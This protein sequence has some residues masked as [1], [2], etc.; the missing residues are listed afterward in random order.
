V[1]AALFVLC[2]LALLAFAS[3]AR[4]DDAVLRSWWTTTPLSGEY[5]FRAGD[6]PSWASPDFDDSWWETMNVPEEFGWLRG[7]PRGEYAWLRRRV[8]LPSDAPASTGTGLS[9]GLVNGA[10]DVFV[11]GVR[12]GSCGSVE[13]LEYAH[14]SHSCAFEVPAAALTD[15]RT[16]LVALRVRQSLADGT[17]GP[18]SLR[19]LG[20]GSLLFGH[21][22]D[23]RARATADDDLNHLK[24]EAMAVIGLCL[25]L[26]TGIP[27]L[28][29]FA[30]RRELRAHAAFGAMQLFGLW[31]VVW[32]FPAVTNAVG[33]HGTTMMEVVVAWASV[34]LQL[35]FLF[36]F[37]VARRP[38][39]AL[40]IVQAACVVGALACLYYPFTVLSAGSHATQWVTLALLPVILWL[41]VREAMRGNRTARVVGVGFAIYVALSVPLFFIALRD[42][43]RLRLAVF[44]PALAGGV[45]FLCS[46]LVLL[47]DQ[48]A[49]KLAEAE[50][51]NVDL[52]RQIARRSEQLSDA[53]AK[54]G[55]LPKRER[56]ILKD[57]I[58]DER[59]RV[60]KKLGAG[61]MG[62]V[63]EVAKEGTE[64][65]F[66]LK[67]LLNAKDGASLAR[68]AREAQIAA[69]VRH[70][71]LVAVKDV[72][73]DADG[74]LYVVMELV[75][76][77]SLDSLEKSWGNVEWAR[78]ILR[79]VASGLAA[80]HAAGVVHRDLKPQ[81]VMLTEA[82]VAKLADFGIARIDEDADLAA[83][84]TVEAIDPALAPTEQGS[85]RLT[86][87][88]ALIGTPAYMAP[89]HAKGTAGTGSA[90]DIWS[91]GVLACEL[92][93]R[94]TP[95]DAPPVYF[96][97]AGKPVPEPKIGESPL[98][99]LVARC[100]SID[101]ADRPTAA[102][103]VEALA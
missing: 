8:V 25:S 47:S 77:A 17:G 53:L 4:A 80:L 19:R 41:I 3:I 6:D 92:T 29:L 87:D 66:A 71:N 70:P 45:A 75:D 38:G 58:V 10:Y 13:P 65:R 39:R 14:P 61:G 40:T 37:I 78:P 16:A 22:E 67:V 96:A 35:E 72:D 23:V 95:F 73:V 33:I 46:V 24:A 88:G 59:Y 48:F 94:G 57:Q 99:P 5:R 1:R 91:F 83:A 68:F 60:L 98:A 81:N 32:I 79:Q 28:W 89:E 103:M 12:V 44:T 82:G 34:P 63:Y 26:L 43:A 52:Q 84:K 101:P 69:K 42:P 93:T 7:R 64:E 100:L 18:F 2:V 55:P 49:R 36:Q 51:L 97:L 31:Q 86:R 21:L 85:E 54:L 20:N 90:G 9:F 27:S 30:R 62:A 15:R 56:K 102:E 76:G 50:A 11:N 74:V